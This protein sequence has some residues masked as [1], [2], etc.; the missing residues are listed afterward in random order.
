MFNSLHHFIIRQYFTF[1]CSSPQLCDASWFL[2]PLSWLQYFTKIA[3]ELSTHWHFIMGQCQ[4]G[5]ELALS[6]LFC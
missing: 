2:L 4:C 3:T 5:S 6:V 1:Q